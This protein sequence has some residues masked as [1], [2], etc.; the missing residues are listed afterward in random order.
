[1]QTYLRMGGAAVL[2][3]A[4]IWP[5]VA[6][7][8]GSYAYGN[9]AKALGDQQ[10]FDSTTEQGRMNKKRNALLALRAEGLKLRDAD[11]GKLTPQHEVYLQAKLDAI[12]AGNY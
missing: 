9:S 2:A 3:L 5:Q 8:A 4:T 1:M 7:S 10:T 12:N 6:M 11:G